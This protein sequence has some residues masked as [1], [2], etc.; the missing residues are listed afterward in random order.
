MITIYTIDKI[1]YIV[2]SADWME[3][4]AV[5]RFNDVLRRVKS[6]GYAKVLLHRKVKDG[7]II[8]V[9]RGVYS[10]SDDVYVIAS[11]LYFPSYLSFLSASY[12]HGFTETIPV[13]VYVAC[14][15][16]HPTLDVLGYRIV[17]SRTR[18]MRGYHKEGHDGGELFLADVEK[19]MV[20]AFLHPGNM[21]GFP[22]IERVFTGAPRPDV[23]KL[24]EHLLALGSNKVYR[25]VGCMLERHAGIDISGLMGVDRNYHDL[26]PFRRGDG[27]CR[28]WR[29]RT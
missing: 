22:E 7:S 13:T 29:L 12:L 23:G 10:A 18:P 28:K 26:D 8:R 15:K 11:N 19:L 24:K 21:G 5:I 27:T 2:T 20:D 4:R 1:Y 3:G 25:Q 6:R 17:F 9:K 14:A 16:A